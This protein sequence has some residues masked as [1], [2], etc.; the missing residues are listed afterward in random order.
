MQK[1]FNFIFTFKT[2]FPAFGFIKNGPIL[3]E[4][5]FKETFGVNTY[6]NTSGLRIYGA[7]SYLKGLLKLELRK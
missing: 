3:I 7:M 5:N 4:T 2:Y 1:S 6:S